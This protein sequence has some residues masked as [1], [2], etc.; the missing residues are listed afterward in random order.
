[1]VGS[2]LVGGRGAMTAV[3]VL[4]YLNSGDGETLGIEDV[5]LLDISANQCSEL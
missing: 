1:M 3:E 4:R 2:S 5:S